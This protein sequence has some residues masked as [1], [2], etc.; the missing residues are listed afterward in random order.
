MRLEALLRSAG[1]DDPIEG[2]GPEVVR[3][4]HDTRVVCDAAH[5]RATALYRIVEPGRA[6]QRLQA[7]LSPRSWP[8]RPQDGLPRPLR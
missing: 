1:L 3:V 5:L 8:R 2:V 4:A 6:E 7:H